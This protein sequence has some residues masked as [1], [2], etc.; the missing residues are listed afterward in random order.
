MD[1]E[2]FCEEAPS[3]NSLLSMASGD[4]HHLFM[5]FIG[6]LGCG[7]FILMGEFPLWE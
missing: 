6:E 5:F 7:T 4:S 1:R 2:P 3:T